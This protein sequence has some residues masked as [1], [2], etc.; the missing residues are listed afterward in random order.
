MAVDGGLCQIIIDQGHVGEGV[1]AHWDVFLGLFHLGAVE[2]SLVFGI[3]QLFSPGKKLP[4]TS[5]TSIFLKLT[6]LSF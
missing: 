4:C 2:V 1:R 5:R 3:G 6:V